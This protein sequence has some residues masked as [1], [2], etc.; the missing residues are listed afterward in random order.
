[1]INAGGAVCRGMQGLVPGGGDM[2]VDTGRRACHT[3]RKPWALAVP[4][5]LVMSVGPHAQVLSW[6]LFG[7]CFHVQWAAAARC[8]AAKQQFWQWFRRRAVVPGMH[9]HN[10]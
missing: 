8:C 5:L 9:D 4:L 10:M 1:M 7:P 2:R 3:D 6:R